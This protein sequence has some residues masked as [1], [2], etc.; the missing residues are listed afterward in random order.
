MAKTTLAGHPLHPQLIS[1]PLGMLPFSLTMDVLH[2]RTGKQSYAD[3]AYY[4]LLGGFIGGMAA[5]AA[6]AVDYF[7]IPARSQAKPTANIHALLNVSLLGLTAIN[8]LLRK[9]NR[10]RRSGPW[11][12]ALSALANAGALVSSWYG[13]H[14][15]YAHGLRVKGVSEIEAAPDLKLPGDEALVETFEQ[16]QHVAAPVARPTH[17]H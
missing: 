6:G 10:K 2:Q 3:A 5:G 9:N 14:L 7:A 13:G 4:S 1:L 8:L 16:L 11:P 15:V 17:L 12:L